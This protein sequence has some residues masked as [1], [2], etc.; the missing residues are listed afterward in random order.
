MYN[1][2]DVYGLAYE[3]PLKKR[4]KTCPFYTTHNLSFKEKVLWIKNHTPYHRDLMI[5]QH[6]NCLNA[7]LSGKEQVS[8]SFEKILIK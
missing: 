7:R 6:N 1:S 2:D 3:C 5:E 4:K 8:L